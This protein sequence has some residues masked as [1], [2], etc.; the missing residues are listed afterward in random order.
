[1]SHDVYPHPDFGHILRGNIDLNGDGL[2]DVVAGTNYAIGPGNII[3][4]VVIGIANDGTE[5]FSAWN[6]PGEVYAPGIDK[7]CPSTTSSPCCAMR[8][9]SWC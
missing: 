4:S 7:F 5:L 6:A 2:P 9:S 3:G 1:M 8:R